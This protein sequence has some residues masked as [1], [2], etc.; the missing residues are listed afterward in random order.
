[1]G[2]LP[3]GDV[4]RLT[5]LRHVDKTRAREVQDVDKDYAKDKSREARVTVC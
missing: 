2:G 3:R 5:A 4:W 1:M